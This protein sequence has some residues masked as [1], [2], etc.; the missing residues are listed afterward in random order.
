[1]PMTRRRLAAFLALT[2]LP[3]S[4]PE[5]AGAAQPV[6]AKAR[7]TAVRDAHDGYAVWYGGRFHGRRTASGARFDANAMTAAHRSLPFGS[8]VRVT[9]L[10][11]GRS[12]VV[13]IEDR[14]RHRG[15]I[16][17]LSAG[18]A[19]QIGLTRSGR[20]P[21]RLTVLSRGEA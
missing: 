10:R 15:A 5:A 1:M 7:R 2:F 14:L 16:I 12:V 3:L 13:R 18:A 20:A 19:R 6:L 4:L 11:N 9:N 21:V 8:Q 17:D